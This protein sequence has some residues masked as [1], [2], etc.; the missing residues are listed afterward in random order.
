MART[1]AIGRKQFKKG[2]LINLTDGGETII[3]QIFSES[4]R[5]K[6]SIANKGKL[7]GSRNPMYNKKHIPYE[8]YMIG[9]CEEY[10]WSWKMIEKQFEEILKKRGLIK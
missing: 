9:R 5:R 4:H 3:N 10:G 6:I 7:T 1:N 8:K 2:P